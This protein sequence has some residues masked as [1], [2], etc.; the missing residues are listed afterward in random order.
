MF[1]FTHTG[2]APVDNP[3]PEAALVE[4]VRAGDEMAFAELYRKFAPLVH[5]VVLARVPYDEV[6]DIVQEVFIAAYKNIGKLRETEKVGAW[7]ASIARNLATEYYRRSKPTDELTDDIRGV[8][9]RRNEAAEVMAAI[10]C[11]PE[12]YRETLVL[13]LVEGMSGNEIAERTGMRPDSVR[14]NLHRGMDMLRKNLGISAAK[15]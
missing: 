8:K 10:R 6:Q 15:K 5:G 13:R 3:R 4:R 2:T 9:D 1:L 14:V 11:L 12:S 7:L